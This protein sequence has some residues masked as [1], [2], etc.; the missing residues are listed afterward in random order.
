MSGLEDKSFDLVFTAGVL[1]YVDCKSV[2]RIIPNIVRIAKK[3]I[4]NIERHGKDKLF[5]RIA[6]SGHKVAMFETNYIKKYKSIDNAMEVKMFSLEK[7]CPRLTKKEVKNV[8]DMI[9][10]N[11]T[12]ES[13]NVFGGV[14]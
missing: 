14:K 5:Q 7:C 13:L 4:I 10:I 2:G 6:V 8:K 1:M 9:L 3:F 12:K 11:L